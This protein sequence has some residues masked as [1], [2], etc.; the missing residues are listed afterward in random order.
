M[1]PRLL[2]LTLIWDYHLLVWCPFQ[3][4]IIFKNSF[5]TTKV[6]YMHY[7]D[8]GKDKKYNNVQYNSPHGADTV[9]ISCYPII[10]VF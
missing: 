2:C 9:C 6:I 10:Y 1:Q 3:V 8:L 4:S 5:L 7:K